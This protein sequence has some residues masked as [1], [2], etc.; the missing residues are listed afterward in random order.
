MNVWVIRVLLT[1][2][3]QTTK[4]HS[5]VNVTQDSVEMAS[6]VIVCISSIII[7]KFNDPPQFT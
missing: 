2:N 5:S 4:V 6:L 1:V 7:Y 3:V